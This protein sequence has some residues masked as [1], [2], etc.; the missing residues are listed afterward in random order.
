MELERSI[1]SLLFAQFLE[2]FPS[3]VN[4]SRDNEPQTLS[5]YFFTS[6]KADDHTLYGFEA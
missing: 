4:H 1:P 5:Y 6:T 2:I 3:L